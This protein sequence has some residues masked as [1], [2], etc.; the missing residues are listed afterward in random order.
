MHMFVKVLGCVCACVCVCGGQRRIVDSSL[1]CSP[2]WFCVEV[3]LTPSSSEILAGQ[4]S[5]L[6]W[7]T[8][9]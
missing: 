6:F 5:A 4:T 1:S 9:G 3:S 7:V 8:D 2:L